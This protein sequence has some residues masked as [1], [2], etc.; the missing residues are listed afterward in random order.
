MQNW[1]DMLINSKF[2]NKQMIELMQDNNKDSVPDLIEGK[3]SAE[4]IEANKVINMEQFF[5]TFVGGFQKTKNIT[6]QLNNEVKI[7]VEKTNNLYHEDG[8]D[9]N[10]NILFVVLIGAVFAYFIFK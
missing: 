4:D 6:N 2:V 1:L 10:R 5:S 9:K 8:Q 7:P 3:I